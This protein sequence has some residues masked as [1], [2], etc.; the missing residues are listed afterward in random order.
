MNRIKLG[1]ILAC[2]IFTAVIFP[3]RYLAMDAGV[4]TSSADYANHLNIS[5]H[6]RSMDIFPSFSEKQ[7]GMHAVSKYLP[8]YHGLLGFH[9]LARFAETLGIPLPGAYSLIMDLSLL[10]ILI[11]FLFIALDRF[12]KKYFIEICLGFLVLFTYFLSYFMEGIN[13]AFFSQLLSQALFTIT[14]YLLSNKYIKTALFT[15]LLATITYPD[16]LIWTAPIL[17]L[18][19]WNKYSFLKIPLTFLWLLILW[20]P[21]HRSNLAGPVV[22]SPSFVALSILF[23]AIFY[24]EILK[25]NR[26]MA[27]SSLAFASYT[28]FLFA[29]STKLFTPSYYASKLASFSYLLIPYLLLHTSIL[30][31]PAH[32]VFI[33][34]ATVVLCFEFT[35]S[36]SW[37][38]NLRSISTFSNAD[39]L[40]GR[41]I[42]AEIESSVLNQNCSRSTTYP[43]VFE[44]T[45]NHFL[46]V[47][48]LGGML[49]NYDIY[50]GNIRSTSLN[51]FF[52]GTT[53]GSLMTMTNSALTSNPS[54]WITSIEKGLQNG[55]LHSDFC[56]A[57]PPESSSYFAKSQYFEKLYEGAK[58][59]YF[60]PQKR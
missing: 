52:S 18:A 24:M 29:A 48:N 36:D 10:S 5:E 2:I 42:I 14:I 39:Y 1:L 54:V 4:S 27:I 46:K 30:S 16:F 23:I 9:L 17:L 57:I 35:G 33:V 43:L 31:K 44:T 12:Q 47:A 21:F 19:K 28:V 38:V 45:T 13:L 50:S 49:T 53:L 56:L 40:S 8:I 25:T 58:F 37:P 55:R 6:V 26:A 7:I 51:E 34:V 15:G 59:V 11:I 60:K 20:Q 32:R 3:Q 41:N 22:T